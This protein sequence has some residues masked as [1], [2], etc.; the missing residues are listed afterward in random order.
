MYIDFLKGLK[1]SLIV[2]MDFF[3]TVVQVCRGN[4]IWKIEF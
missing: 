3:M 4:V 1:V 2:G